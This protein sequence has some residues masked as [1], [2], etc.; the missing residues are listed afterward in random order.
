MTVTIYS[1]ALL[2]ALLH[3]W[4][5]GWALREMIGALGLGFR[6][7]GAS[8]FLTPFALGVHLNAVWFLFAWVLFPGASKP[9]LAVGTA[10]LDLII[11]GGGIVLSRR[12]PIRKGRRVPAYLVTVAILGILVG[13]F[14]CFQVPSV[15]DSIQI[16]QIQHFVLGWGWNAADNAAT[17]AVARAVGL[18]TGTIPCPPMP[19]FSGIMLLPALL[20]GTLPVATTSAGMKVLLVLMAAFVSAHVGERLGLRPRLMVTLVL[21]AGLVLSRFGMYGMINLG[22]DSIFAV[23]MFI[24]AAVS[25]VGDKTGRHRHESNLYFSAA[26]FLG[27]VVVPYGLVFWAIY[28][29]LSLGRARLLPDLVSLL[30]WT[31]LA[32]P[33]S[34]AGIQS[35]LQAGEGSHQPLLILIVCQAVLILGLCLLR[36]F[37]GGAGQDRAWLQPLT[38]FVPLVAFVFCLCLMPAVAHIAVWTDA[39]GHAVMEERAPLD[40]H[41]RF[42]T[43]LL[44]SFRE[45]LSP[46][47]LVAVL[48][49]M[50]LP[51]A[52]PR[53]R[54]PGFVALFSFLPVTLV[55]VLLHLKLGLHGLTDFNI[56]DITKNVPQWFVGPIF[57][58]FAVLTIST[59]RGFLVARGI[60][61]AWMKQGSMAVLGVTLVLA[62]LV[63]AARNRDFRNAIHV[64]TLTRPT[65]TAAG[66][67]GDPDVAQAM[68]FVW[69]NARGKPVFVSHASIFMG[70]F[71]LYQMFGAG[72]TFEFDQRLLNAEFPKAYPS[73]SFL[74]DANDLAKVEDFARSSKASMS[75]STTRNRSYLVRVSFNGEGRVSGNG[76]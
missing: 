55:L 13:T 5:P 47:I 40:G 63:V 37:M 64:H 31:L 56:W 3:V 41:T 32:L 38:P 66:G 23:P 16:L 2:T 21:F 11:I 15:L 19:G 28:L 17:G 43:Y 65:V 50:L 7:T 34:I 24:A 20:Q 51:F 76:L 57:T 54:Q 42:V 53:Y 59:L 8:R 25:L 46:V 74:L 61:R 39:F 45:N 72:S 48:G 69:A 70:G 71:Y 30:A 22:K 9:Y 62:V 52:K 14:A 75:V 68:A 58:A 10:V 60:G 4:L 36:R 27:S 44:R 29:T 33:V 35:S 6:R 1:I 49:C 12:S 18:L 26:I 73:V 67:Y